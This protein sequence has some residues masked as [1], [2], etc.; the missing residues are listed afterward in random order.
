MQIY[1]SSTFRQCFCTF[2]S[3]NHSSLFCLFRVVYFLLILFMYIM[4]MVNRRFHVM[5]F[6]RSFLFSL[7]KI[8]WITGFLLIF[9]KNVFEVSLIVKLK[10]LHQLY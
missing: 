2:A 6:L 1:F 7:G 3:F 5:V 4:L 8:F 10:I 9:I